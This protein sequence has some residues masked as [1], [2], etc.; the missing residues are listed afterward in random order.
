MKG[1][2][3]GGERERFVDNVQSKNEKERE[4]NLVGE[5]VVRRDAI[6]LVSV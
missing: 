5:T 3:Q 4:G 1:G 6:G 2:L